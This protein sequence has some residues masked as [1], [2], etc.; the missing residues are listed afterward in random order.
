MTAEL[1]G[2]DL[3]SLSKAGAEPAGDSA[4]RNAAD[5]CGGKP[6]ST[7]APNE[8][9]TRAAVMQQRAEATKGPEDP[10]TELG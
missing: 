9:D 4:R 8:A 1:I 7:R 5:T 6:N 3:L 2:R 10:E